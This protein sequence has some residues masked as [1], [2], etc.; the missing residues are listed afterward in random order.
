MILALTVVA[1]VFCEK[2]G[3]EVTLTALITQW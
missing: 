2:N 1:N 3:G